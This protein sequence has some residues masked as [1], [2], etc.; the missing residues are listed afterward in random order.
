MTLTKILKQKNCL[1]PMGKR[2][3]KCFFL[4]LKLYPNSS[5][6]YPSPI[7]FLQKILNFPIFSQMLIDGKNNKIKCHIQ[8]KD[9][10]GSSCQVNTC[11]HDWSFPKKSQ[12]VKKLPSLYQT[13]LREQL[14][15]QSISTIP[16]RQNSCLV[17][18]AFKIKHW[19]DVC[20]RKE[21]EKKFIT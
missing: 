4:S 2:F 8:S 16:N 11:F 19:A 5:K 18:S 17:C 15:H 1:N 21:E 20:N 10:C 9:M 12:F 13:K 14:S 3:L 7:F 6:K